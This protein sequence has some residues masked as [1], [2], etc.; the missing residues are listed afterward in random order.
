MS[1]VD[2]P[3]VEIRADQETQS[4]GTFAYIAA[5]RGEFESR[6]KKAS[7]LATFAIIA[8]IATLMHF[9]KKPS[10]VASGDE[11]NSHGFTAPAMTLQDV[12]MNPK[13]LTEKD[14][15][16]LIPHPK[17]MTSTYGKIRV[18]SLRSISQLPIGSEMHAVLASG[19][20][21]GI[22]KAVLINPLIVDGEPVLPERAV[23]FG[24]GRSGE[25]RLFVEFSKVILPTG[26]SYPIRA[27]AFDLTDQILGLKGAIVGTRTKKMAGA[28]AFG[29]VGGMAAGLQDTS[30]SFFN[31]RKPTLRDGALAGASKASLDQ[32]QA[33]MDEMKK[34]PN[35]IEVKAGTNI[36]VM[37]DEPK[38]KNETS[39]E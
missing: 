14:L 4:L 33:F 7:L 39:E 30:G 22:V 36:V 16:N 38:K 28:I 19:A 12:G 29:L 2:L 23:L 25:T 1:E 6:G 35:I 32:S 9:S 13:L 8:A 24:K 31:Q 26:E 21:D 11:S 17:V 3:V 20:T 5:S 27:Q 37:T 18:L 15:T 34:S 10:P